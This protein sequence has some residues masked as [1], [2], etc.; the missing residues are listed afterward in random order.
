MIVTTEAFADQLVKS[1]AAEPRLIQTF[2]DAPRAKRAATPTELAKLAVRSHL[3]TRYQAEEILNSRGRRLRVNDYV[4]QEVLGYGGMGLVY[5]AKRLER[6]QRFALKLLAERFKHD[7]GMRARFQLEGKAGILLEHPHLVR[8]H[9]LGRREDLYG[10]TD[11]MVME[12][13]EGVTLLEGISF[14][15]GPMKWDAAC[16]VVCQAAKGLGYVHERGMV[17]RDVKPDNILVDVHGGA[18]LLDF[19]LALA[20]QQVEA[21]EYSLAMIFGQDCLGTA[22]YIPPE[23]SLDSLAVDARADI[24]SLGCTLYVA[25]TA[26]RPFPLEHRRDI[27]EAHRAAPRPRVDAVN[28]Q[29]PRAL[30]DVIERMMAVN[31]ADRPANMEEVRDLLKPYRRRRNWAFEFKHVLHRRR[32]LKKAIMTKSRLNTLQAGRSTKLNA[33]SST[34]PPGLSAELNALPPKELGPGNTPARE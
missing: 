7:V 27:L 15:K 25:L 30:V 5:V 20:D 14:A 21:E 6:D 2:L 11:F 12:L 24:Y 26:R 31:P 34:D 29:P 19:G 17:H 32:E 4:L 10:E 22:D 9:E 33:Q 28:S 16:D 23:Q 1:R 3:L 18:K 8:T 13:F